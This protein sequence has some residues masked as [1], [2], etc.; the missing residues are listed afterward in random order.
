MSLLL[1]YMIDSEVCECCDVEEWCDKKKCYISGSFYE[2]SIKL[3]IVKRKL[4]IALYDALPSWLK[5]ILER[6]RSK[7]DG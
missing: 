3:Y 2:A 6:M 4:E 1:V 5:R 7:V